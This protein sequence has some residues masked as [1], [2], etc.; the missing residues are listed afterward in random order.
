MIQ[1]IQTIYLLIVL[2]M[3]SMTLT[4]NLAT[5]T[6]ADAAQSGIPSEVT[7]KALGISD[8]EHT[9]NIKATMSLGI[10]ASLTAAL[11]FISIVS[12]KKRLF[13][14]RLCAMQMVLLVGAIGYTI[15]YLINMT[16]M[17]DSVGDYATH[18]SVVNGAPLIAL[19]FA[20]L[21]MKAILRDEY[22]VRGADRIR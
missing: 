1:R 18:I 10:L 14:V 4:C 3:M 8:G 5:F 13:Q 2:I 17:M 7:F 11:A 20:R 16:K 6:L 9:T 21:A 15:Y 22:L 19:L 12:F